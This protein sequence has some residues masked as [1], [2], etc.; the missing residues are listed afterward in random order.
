MASQCIELHPPGVYPMTGLEET[1]GNKKDTIP[2]L[3]RQRGN[4][5]QRAKCWETGE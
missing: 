4:D 5:I 3:T 1:M 2:N